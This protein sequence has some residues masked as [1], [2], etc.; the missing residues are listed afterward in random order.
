[1]EESVKKKK[2]DPSLAIKM[3]GKKGKRTSS[4]QKKKRTVKKIKSKKDN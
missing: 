4:K 3:S 1:M 2:Y